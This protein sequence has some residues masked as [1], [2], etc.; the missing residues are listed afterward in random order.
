MSQ[1]FHVCPALERAVEALSHHIVVERPF[2]DFTLLQDYP[3]P[4]NRY[5]D[6]DEYTFG[7]LRAESII[8]EKFGKWL[9]VSKMSFVVFLILILVICLT[10]LSILR[11]NQ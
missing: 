10:T 11:H 8:T 3:Q 5:D 7:E 4:L 6:Y 1:F 9:K 2:S